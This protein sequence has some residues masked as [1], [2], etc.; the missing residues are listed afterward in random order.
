MTILALN[1]LFAIVGVLI[2]IGIPAAGLF[3]QQKEQPAKTARKLARDT[4][5]AH[6]AS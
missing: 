2:A 6:Q 5:A 3:W 1:V 4:R